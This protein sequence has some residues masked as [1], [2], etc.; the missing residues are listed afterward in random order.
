[1]PSGPTPVASVS[2]LSLLQHVGFLLVDSFGGD[3]ARAVV[4]VLNRSPD[5]LTPPASPRGPALTLPL[6]KD[7]SKEI[8]HRLLLSSLG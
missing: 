3:M 5:G 7:I 6:S 1:M 8:R 4:F 2:H